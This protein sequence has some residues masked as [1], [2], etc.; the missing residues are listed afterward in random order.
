MITEKK[1]TSP[2]ASNFLTNSLLNFQSNETIF[3]RLLA[4]V[5]K[6]LNQKNNIDMSKTNSYFNSKILVNI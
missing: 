2:F 1:T 3:S 4:V 5:E 6:R